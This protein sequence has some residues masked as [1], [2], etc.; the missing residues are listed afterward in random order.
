MPT[1]IRKPWFKAVA[2]GFSL[3]LLIAGGV[4][5]SSVLA[6][7]PPRSK[8]PG[9]PVGSLLPGEPS[10]PEGSVDLPES[11]IDRPIEVGRFRILSAG[12]VPKSEYGYFPTNTKLEQGLD[13][14]NPVQLAAARRVAPTIGG[15]TPPAGFALRDGG[16]DVVTTVSGGV[17]VPGEFYRFVRDDQFPVELR[18][19][20]IK[21]GSTVEL[22]DYESGVGLAMASLTIQSVPLVIVHGTSDAKVQPVSQA[23][24]MVGDY[25]V[26]VDAPALPPGIFG[27]FLDSLIQNEPARL[28]P[29]SI[30]AIAATKE[31]QP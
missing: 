12:S 15:V 24:F 29:M 30:A 26:N 22:V 5:A 10:A 6:D 20:L 14:R 19:T 3:G 1:L 17:Y 31:F 8:L 7:D 13:F 28:A 23:W 9:A 4:W 21:P 27:D 25:L 18:I 11:T 16:A 2:A